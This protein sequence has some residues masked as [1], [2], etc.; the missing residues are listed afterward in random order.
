MRYY[1][2]PYVVLRVLFVT[3]VDEGSTCCTA[4]PFV[5]T[6]KQKGE[7]RRVNVYE[8]PSKNEKGM[9]HCPGLTSRVA[10]DR[11]SRNKHD[12]Y[13]KA[14]TEKCGVYC[15]SSAIAA[16]ALPTGT[17]RG[18]RLWGIQCKSKGIIWLE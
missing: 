11:E 8:Q 14:N 1:K 7:R 9:V 12:K 17:N 4:S 13:A 3:T 10:K 18:I 2:Y 5:V 16:S 15:V 6:S